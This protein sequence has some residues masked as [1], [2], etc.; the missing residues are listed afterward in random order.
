MANEVQFRGPGAGAQCY[1]TIHNQTSGM[2]WNTSG[3][4]GAYE[5][6][7]SGNWSV[8]AISASEQGLSNFF[9]GNIPAAV[10]AGVLSIDVRQSVTGGELQTDPGVAAGDIQWNGSTVVPL[11]NLATSGQLASFMPVQLARGQAVSGFPLY[12]KSSL[13]HVTPLVSGVCSGSVSKNGGLFGPLQSGIFNEI[14]LGAYT[15]GLTSGDVNAESLMFLFTAT[16]VSGPVSDPLPI[17]ILTM[18]G[19]V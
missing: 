10:P 19:G 3:G 14:G 1:F 18:K 7:N 12:F 9:V 11:S 5:G 2:I 15:V 4:T 13:D 16:N 8:Y 6:F 17:A